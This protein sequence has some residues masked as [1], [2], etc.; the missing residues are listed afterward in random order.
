MY[1][2]LYKQQGIRNTERFMDFIVESKRFDFDFIFFIGNLE[3]LSL[4]AIFGKG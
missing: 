2:T 1:K 3:I 4:R